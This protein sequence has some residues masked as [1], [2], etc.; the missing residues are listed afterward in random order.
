[1]NIYIHQTIIINQLKT[2]GIVNSSVFQIGT[3]GNINAKTI[4]NNTGDYLSPAP[5]ITEPGQIVRTSQE[6]S[7]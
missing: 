4:T 1:M 3:S 6:D 7:I 5:P 2:G